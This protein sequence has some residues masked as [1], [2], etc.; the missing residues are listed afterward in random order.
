M[1]NIPD[2]PGQSTTFASETMVKF[3][4]LPVMVTSGRLVWLRTLYY[5]SQIQHNTTLGLHFVHS[6]YTSE[7]YAMRKLK[8]E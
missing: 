3:A 1:A 8:G 2:E 4:I 6:V 5:D 7:E